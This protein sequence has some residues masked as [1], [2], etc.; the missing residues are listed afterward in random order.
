M[1]NTEVAIA[2]RVKNI[3]I[4]AAAAVIRIGNILDHAVPTVIHQQDRNIRIFLLCGRQLAQRDRKPPSPVSMSVLRPSA[5]RPAPR[6]FPLAS[7]V[8]CRRPTHVRHPAVRRA[9]ATDCPR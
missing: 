8:R 2:D 4:R 5:E 7:P 6:L 3:D 9:A 1:R